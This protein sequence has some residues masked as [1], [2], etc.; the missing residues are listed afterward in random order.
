MIYVDREEKAKLK[1]ERF[2]E[3]EFHDRIP[4]VVDWVEKDKVKIHPRIL[5]L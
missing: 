1:G 2:G 4:R 5:S 3:C